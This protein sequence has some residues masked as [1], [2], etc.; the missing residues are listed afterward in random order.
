MSSRPQAGNVTAVECKRYGASA[1]SLRELQ[2][3]L[4]QVELA[5]RDLDLWVLVSSRDLN[6]RLTEGLH[7]LS[8]ENGHGFL[9]ISSADGDPSSLEALISFAP[10]VTANHPAI[11]QVSAS[12]EIRPLLQEIAGRPSFVAR[13]SA[14]KEAFTSPLVGYGNWRIEQNQQFLRTL[15]SEQQAQASYGQPIHVEDPQVK[16]I[17]RDGL[18]AALDQW[19]AAWNRDRVLAVLGEEGDGKTWGVTS[20][21]ADKVKHNPEFPG[22]IFLSSDGVYETEFTARDLHPLFSR[23]IKERLLGITN[24]QAERRLSRWTNRKNQLPLFLLVLDGTNERRSPSFW[25]GLLEQL[26]GEPWS[27]SIRILITC[28]TAFWKR[29]FAGL[30]LISAKTFS[31]GPF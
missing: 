16:L 3:E 9:A 2:G 6:S 1:L 4:V 23:L 24:D 17:R 26:G 5:V 8:V 10:E 25:R 29:H 12:D 7:A 19:S 28:R 11:L 18:W 20:W 15:I 30:R 21:L 13:I 14:L 31:L 22:V 27:I